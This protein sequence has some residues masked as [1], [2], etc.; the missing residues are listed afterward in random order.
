M[1]LTLLAASLVLL[2]ACSEGRTEHDATTYFLSQCAGCTVREVR[3]SE[4][5]VAAQTFSIAYEDKGQS[6]KAMVMFMRDT[7]VW[8]L[9][10]E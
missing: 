7:Q 9:H 4:D 3:M 8:S 2:V 1:R 5:E 6:K 10:N